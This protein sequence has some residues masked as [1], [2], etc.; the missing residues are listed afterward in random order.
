MLCF[1]DGPDFGHMIQ[2]TSG[3]LAVFALNFRFCAQ[4][5]EHSTS[6]APNES[7]SLASLSRSLMIG[8]MAV[9]EIVESSSDSDTVFGSFLSR[10]LGLRFLRL[11]FHQLHTVELFFGLPNVSK[12]KS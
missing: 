7:M 8:P 1:Q 10:I 6:E 5:V 9:A 4:L 3:D 11:S 12:S 2:T